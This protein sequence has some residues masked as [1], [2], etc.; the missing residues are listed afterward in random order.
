VSIA[1]A[2]AVLAAIEEQELQEN[3]RV[4]GLQLRHG[5]AELSA[6][7]EAIGDIRGAGLYAGVELVSSR[8]GKEPVPRFANSVINGMRDRHVLISVCGPHNSILKIRPLLISSEG[9]VS[10]LL[11]ALE[12]TL[13]EVEQSL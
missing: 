9:D 12:A 1:A 3:S 13:S 10:Q 2:A 8:D 11:E 7:H 5:L 6:R 4:R